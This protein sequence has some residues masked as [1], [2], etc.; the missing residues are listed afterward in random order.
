MVFAG[1]FY[2]NIDII[3]SIV[4]FGSLFTYLF[5]NLA[6]IKLRRSEPQTQRGFKV[7][8]YPI[9]PILGAT[10]CIGLMYFLSDSAKIVSAAYAILGLA[11]YFFIYRNKKSILGNTKG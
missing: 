6:L 2:N 9:V 10:S 11:I 5:V 3:A 8:V 4:N 1:L 7:P